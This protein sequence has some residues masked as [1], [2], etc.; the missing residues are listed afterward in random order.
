MISSALP[1]IFSYD[2]TSLESEDLPTAEDEILGIGPST[3]YH[4]CEPPEAPWEPHLAEFSTTPMFLQ[5]W[6]WYERLKTCLYATPNLDAYYA[7]I[8]ASEDKGSA[9]SLASAVGGT[10]WHDVCHPIPSRISTFS[11]LQVLSPESSLV[12]GDE[13]SAL[14][15]I[16]DAWQID[17]T[18]DDTDWSSIVAELQENIM[19]PHNETPAD[20]SLD[21]SGSQI[22]ALPDLSTVSAME[23]MKPSEAPHAGP[24]T[25][26]QTLYA[27][28]NTNVSSNLL[29]GSYVGAVNGPAVLSRAGTEG[30]P[31]IQDLRPY[32]SLYAP[33]AFFGQP[34]SISVRYFAGNTATYPQIAPGTRYQAS[35]GKLPIATAIGT[36]PTSAFAGPYSYSIYTSPRSPPP[37]T[38]PYI[39]KRLRSANPKTE[40]KFQSSAKTTHGDTHIRYQPAK[41]HTGVGE[42]IHSV[43]TANDAKG[44]QL[45]RT[46]MRR[47]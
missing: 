39:S 9:A 42:G 25:Q 11:A 26:V 15:S 40:V 35:Y 2:S 3:Y 47:T 10:R 20:P 23:C 16:S 14:A 38:I 17:S 32:S 4:A 21:I 8:D 7:A 27:I 41:K 34:P 44:H 29:D 13:I 18:S 31:T 45:A 37:G 5:T 36:W 19:K 46:F 22:P 43:H 24:R 6:E 33:L 30:L 12:Q 1:A 28:D